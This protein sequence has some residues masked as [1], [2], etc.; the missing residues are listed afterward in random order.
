MHHMNPTPDEI[1]YT[2]EFIY[3]LVQFSYFIL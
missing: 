1:D 3:S 2:V